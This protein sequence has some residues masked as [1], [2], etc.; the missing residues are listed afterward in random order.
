MS[1]LQ[2]EGQHESVLLSPCIVFYSRLV[3]RLARG[4]YTY[5]ERICRLFNP[6][7][8]LCF[9]PPVCQP[10]THLCVFIDT[11]PPSLLFVLTAWACSFP[12]S[13]GLMRC[14][15]G[16]FVNVPLQRWRPDPSSLDCHPGMPQLASGR[17]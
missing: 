7:S 10:R 5:L 15:I 14:D 2:R 13:T 4:Y 1:F 6:T 9:V 11:I 12:S 8:P 3:L 17:G 16:D